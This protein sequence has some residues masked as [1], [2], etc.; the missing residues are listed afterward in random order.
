MKKL[1]ILFIFVVVFVGV[2]IASAESRFYKAN[3]IHIKYV[4][5]YR[6]YVPTDSPAWDE[7]PIEYHHAEMWTGNDT[8][9][10]GYS[11]VTL[12]DRDE[13]EAPV[14]IGYIREDEDGWV[15]RYATASRF[16]GVDGKI[17]KEKLEKWGIANKWVFLYDFSR[18][19]WAV[20]MQIESWSNSPQFD[21]QKGG[22]RALGTKTLLNG[23]E[24]PVADGIIYGIG[25][26]KLLFEGNYVNIFTCWNTAILEYWRDGELL[27]QNESPQSVDDVLMTP[28]SLEPMYDLQGRPVDGTQK[29]ILIR[30]GKK[31]LVN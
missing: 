16:S 27:I 30:N 5:Y 1:R 14:C 26:P 17:E 21:H 13:G 25:Y 12:W 24:V 20:G 4:Y 31:V 2:T 22:I 19:D 8:I 7:F 18:S 28:S 29:G 10:D 9:V 6:I 15:W 3:N 23:E 11:C